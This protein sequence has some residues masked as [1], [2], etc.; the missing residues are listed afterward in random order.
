MRISNGKN[1]DGD[2]MNAE[3]KKDVETIKKCL[4]GLGFVCNSIPS[5]QN[6]VF[7]KNNEVVIIK[8]CEK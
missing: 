2:N 1:L 7:Y 6:L 8:N 5:A 4:I 3:E